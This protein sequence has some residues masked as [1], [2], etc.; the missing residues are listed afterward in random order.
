LAWI[1]SDQRQKN[2]SQPLIRGDSREIQNI[3]ENP[4]EKALRFPLLRLAARRTN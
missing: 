1:F 3:K 4:H 2:P